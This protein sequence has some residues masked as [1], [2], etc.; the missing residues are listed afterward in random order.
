MST[1]LGGSAFVA[2]RFLVTE[3]EPVTIAFLRTLI[4]ATVLGSIAL[5]IIRCWPTPRELFMMCIMG[6]L[7]FGVMQLIFSNAFVYTTSSRGALAFASAP[8][9]ALAIAAAF[10]IEKPTWQKIL[11]IVVATTG[12]V[13]A[14]AQDAGA[15][16]NAWIGDGLVLSAAMITAVYGVWSARALKHQSPLVSI[17]TGVV[18]GTVLLWAYAMATGAPAFS[19]VLS[20]TGW[21][22]IAYLGIGAAV[23][24]YT[25]WL[26]A[27]RHTTPTLVA[28]SLPINPLMALIWGS[29]LLDE[30]VTVTMIVGFILVISG[31]AITNWQRR[32]KF[33]PR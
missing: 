24:S 33:L 1:A 31:I 21:L 26:W 20:T 2:V 14:L 10:G 3:I 6:T 13:V 16:P 15:P 9:M 23:I 8:F 32:D 29:V 18:P 4:A 17:V 22:S 5:L 7:F 12:V 30:E 25:L 19:P 27:L 28:V 11:G